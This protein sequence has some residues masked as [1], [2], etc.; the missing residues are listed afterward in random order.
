MHNGRS[1][2]ANAIANGANG[3][4]LK[5]H[6]KRELIEAIQ[7]ENDGQLVIQTPETP[8]NQTARLEKE[9]AELTKR[10]KEIVC[11][12][13]NE[14]ITREIADELNIAPTTVERHRQN[15]MAKLEVRNVAGIVRYALENGLC[16]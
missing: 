10:E 3:Y 16:G 9:V 6:G 1:M 5:D 2:I 11:L 12:I 4:V 7:K 13:V 8:G 14:R 15:I